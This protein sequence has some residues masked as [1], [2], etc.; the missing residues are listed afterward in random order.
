[1]AGYA[2]IGFGRYDHEAPPERIEGRPLLGYSPGT[3]KMI[4]FPAIPGSVQW[5]H[6]PVKQT[7]TLLIAAL[8]LSACTIHVTP[9][10]VLL[11]NDY[12]PAIDIKRLGSAVQGVRLEPI[13]LRHADGAISRGVHLVRPGS[14]AVIVYLG[15]N[16]MRLADHGP[17][18]LPRFAMLNAD[19]FWLDYRGQGASEGRSCRAVC[20]T[21]PRARAN[22]CW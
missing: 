4:S 2:N 12:Y 6:L 7:I 18:L 3:A 5:S 19:L 22:C 9:E 1:M 8:Q 10:S 17:G 14:Q 13:S 20:S 15:G 21:V 16:K 11:H